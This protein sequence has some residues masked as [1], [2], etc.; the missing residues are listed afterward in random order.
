MELMKVIR[1]SHQDPTT[2]DTRWV[3]VTFEPVYT[4]AQPITLTQIKTHPELQNIALIKQ[5]QLSV[6]PLTNSE[7]TLF[8]MHFSS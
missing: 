8:T 2:S 1:E 3:S 5:P 7:F 4:F 6:M